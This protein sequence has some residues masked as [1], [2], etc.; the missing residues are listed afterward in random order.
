MLGF[1]SALAKAENSFNKP[2]FTKIEA[3]KELRESGFRWG[4]TQSV[5]QDADAKYLEAKSKNRPQVAIAMRQFFAKIN[6]IQYGVTD[7]TISAIGFGST[8]LESRW[9]FY[10]SIARVEEVEK[11]HLIGVA[12]SQTKQ[13]R[14]DLTAMMLIQYLSVQRLQRQL[15]AFQA[16]IER[17]ET[18][19]NLAK[20]KS[21]VGAGIPLDL[22]RARTLLESDRVKKI[23]V[24]TKLLK[25]KHDLATTLGQESV[26]DN[27]EPLMFRKIDVGD[28]NATLKLALD[29]RPDLKVIHDQANAADELLK[30]TQGLIFPKAQ[31]LASVGSTNTYALGLPPNTLTGMVGLSVE[32]PLETGGLLKSKRQEAAVLVERASLQEKQTKVEILN[33]LKEGLEQ[34]FAAEEAIKGAGDYLKAAYEEV[35]INK[36]RFH[37]GSANLLDYSNSHSNLATAIDT[38][39]EAIFAY[40]A[41]K[42]NFYRVTG[43][44]EPYFADL[45]REDQ[46]E[47]NK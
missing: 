42:V 31:A 41:A 29:Q 6:P 47:L 30:A 13:Y 1:L 22:N 10:D 18:I 20:A 28:V 9:A 44:L 40:E 17:S 21:D 35:R 3:Y 34:L 2:V 32:I 26:P 36:E 11:E 45:K 8:G 24:Y 46:H 12:R 4:L 38:E 7:Q 19:Y 5:V 15:D 39:T 37:V 14:N 43:D 23:Q 16:S 25:A 33:Q 27:L